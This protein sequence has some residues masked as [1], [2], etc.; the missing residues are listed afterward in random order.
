MR[1]RWPRVWTACA[2]LLAMSGT[3]VAGGSGV[4]SGSVR[5][6]GATP[7]RPP[8]PVFKHHEVCGDGVPD[9][10]LVVGPD[11]GLRFAVVSIEGVR[12]ARKP[13]HDLTHVLDNRACRF[14]PH[15][16]VAEVGQWLEIVNSDPILH[17]ADARLGQ[18]TLF[19]VALLPAHR[20]RKPLARPG[21]IAITCDVRHVWMAAFIDVTD[22]P[23]HT[24]TDV[25]GAYEIRDVP[26]GKYTLKV[27]HE[28]LGTL[29]RPLTV[30]SGATATVDVL[31]PAPVSKKE[32]SK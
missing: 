16:Q 13:E 3:A 1:E 6:A 28:E 23:Y 27:W 4:V 15:V 17:N 8:L 2:A 5:V 10:R 12:D 19:N 14:D 21:M 26:P 7:H 32:E 9:D 11:G 22:H 31:Y 25:H 18:E 30:E 29:E 24:V 20:V